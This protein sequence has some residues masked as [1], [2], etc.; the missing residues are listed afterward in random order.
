MVS[1]DAAC[2]IASMAATDLL[3]MERK[4]VFEVKRQ[5]KNNNQREI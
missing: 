5:L 2:I 1:D 4:V 3:I